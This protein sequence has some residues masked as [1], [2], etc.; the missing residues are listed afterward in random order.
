MKV[1]EII[2]N[3]LHNIKQ[4]NLV[5]T[6]D[7]FSE[8]F[9]IEAKRAKIIIEDCQ[10]LEK[11]ISQLPNEIKKI[12]KKRN[13]QSVEQLIRFLSSELMR[14]DTKKSSEIVQAYVLLTKRLL[15]TIEL[16]HNRS[17][18]QMAKED[19][20]KIASFLDRVEIDAIRDHWNS[21]VMEYDD[22]FLDRLD[23]YCKVDKSDLKTMV[24]DIVECIK[25]RDGSNFS[26]EDLAQI[27]IDSMAP[28][29]ASGM[30]DELATIKDQICSNP[31]LLTSKAM[32]DDL[33]DMTKKRIELDKK[34][35]EKQITELDSIIEH[36]SLALTNVISWGDSNHKAIRE[37]QGELDRIDLKADSF[38]MIHAK[39]LAIANSLEDKTK[40]LNEQM[41]HSHKEISDLRKRVKILEEALLKERKRSTTDSL[42]NLLNRRAIDD[43]ISKQESAFN[44]YGDNYAF[45]LFDIDYFKSVNDTYGHDAGDVILS[46][47]G[48][49]IQ[50]YSRDLDFVGRWGGEEFLVVLPKTDKQ[51]ALQ[52]ANKLREIIKKSKFMYKNIRIKITVSGGVAQ[53]VGQT[54]MESMLKHADENLYRAKKSG[55]D[56]IVG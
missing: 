7:V 12:V 47:F 41:S 51:G 55:R 10:K 1:Q 15:Q 6:P 56:K 29:I 3:T 24:D 35:V 4:K 44:R 32:M 52:F 5:L 42:T 28:S 43:F 16:L 8:Q 46:H 45:V 9:C 31:E 19:R 21:F 38:D 14:S 48:K 53:R 25:N 22:S 36:I 23:V 20:D 37:I 50:R 54:S 27:V 2:K 13:V 39:L 11:F 30:N 40:N 33:K 34:A 18:A 26:F 49:L 17:A